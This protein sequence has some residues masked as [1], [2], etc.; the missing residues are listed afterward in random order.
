MAL[1]RGAQ[2]VY[3][4]KRSG[5]Y[6]IERPPVIRDEVLRLKQLEQGESVGAGEV[7]LSK[8]GLPP[9]RVPDRKQGD[10]EIS[11][12]DGQMILDETC[13]IGGE[14]CVASKKTRRFISI[15]QI[16]I[17]R[18]APPIDSVAISLVGCCGSTNG[19]AFQLG[20]LARRDSYSMTVSLLPK[21]LC[22]GRWSEQRDV[23]R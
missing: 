5:R 23:V 4:I 7:S 21:P 19:H 14:R 20:S 9:G 13:G 6:V 18:A 10:I 16:H 8:S 1:K 3:R 22:Y 11:A 15:Y 12:M 2:P 17:G